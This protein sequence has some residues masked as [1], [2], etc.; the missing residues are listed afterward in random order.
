MGREFARIW[1]LDEDFKVGGGA[2]FSEIPPVPLNGEV[3]NSKGCKFHV[4][5]MLPLKFGTKDCPVTLL[6]SMG[7]SSELVK[8][9]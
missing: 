7:F 4:K 2:G 5:C 9:F 3:R 1:Q 6:A 8:V